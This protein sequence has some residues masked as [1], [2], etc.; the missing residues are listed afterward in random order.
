MSP[1]SW[2]LILGTKLLSPCSWLLDITWGHR[3]SVL[4]IPAL[5][6]SCTPLPCPM[7][8]PLQRHP[9][10]NLLDQHFLLPHNGS[11]R[12]STHQGRS[13]AHP[14]AG[15]CWLGPLPLSPIPHPDP[16]PDPHPDLGSGVLG[17]CS[18]L[19]PQQG[20][21]LSREPRK[22]EAGAGVG[23]GPSG[24]AGPGAATGNSSL[25]LCCSSWVVGGG[26][27]PPGQGLISQELWTTT[28]RGAAVGHPR[29]TVQGP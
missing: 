1:R 8:V 28:P 23:S 3:V 4:S 26:T 14:R 7:A 15:L 25:G 16:L 2:L 13:S 27:P 24:S 6:L 29:V 19:T 11:Q 9:L 20:M 5:P 12:P 10:P 17:P 18:I 22:E 21:K